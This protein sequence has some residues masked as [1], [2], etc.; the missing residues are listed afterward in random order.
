MADPKAPTRAELAKFLPDQRTIRAFE[1]LFNIVPSGIEDVGLAAGTALATAQQALGLWS[2]IAD[3]LELLAVAPPEVPQSPEHL[4]VAPPE[5][6]QSPEHL[7][8][9]PPVAVQNIDELSLDPPRVPLTALDAELTD[10]TTGLIKS[11]ATLSSNAGAGAGTLTNAPTA[12]D[13]T[14]WVAVSDNGTTR[15]IPTWT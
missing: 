5:V 11:S 8:V 15:Y 7:D 1:E 12:G 13:P 14:K 6:P 10:N 9:A 3:A 2:R 4:D